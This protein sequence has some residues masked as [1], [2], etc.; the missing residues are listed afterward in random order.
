MAHIFSCEFCEFFM[1][2]FFILIPLGCFSCSKKKN[3]L[4]VT[5]Y[6]ERPVTVMPNISR[7]DGFQIDVD[8]CKIELFPH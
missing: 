3:C 7:F 4:N 1:N 5:S 6:I 2:S 8:N